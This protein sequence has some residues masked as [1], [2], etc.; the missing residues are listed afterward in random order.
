V[1]SIEGARAQDIYDVPLA[2]IAASLAK[3][4]I[5]VTITSQDGKCLELR[6]SAVSGDAAFVRSSAGP[7]VYKVDKQLF[8]DL[9]LA[10]PKP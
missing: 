1:D 9:D 5:V 8:S 10:P 3:A 2:A 7:E 6:V 4:Q